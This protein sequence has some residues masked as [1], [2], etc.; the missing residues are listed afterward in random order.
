MSTRLIY[1]LRTYSIDLIDIYKVGT[2]VSIRVRESKLIQAYLRPSIKWFI[3]S[4]SKGKVIH[5]G[6]TDQKYILIQS[7]VID[8]RIYE[9][10]RWRR[11]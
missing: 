9:T 11:A 4:K 1:A 8:A 7:T 5:I 10:I 3:P 6:F 2:R